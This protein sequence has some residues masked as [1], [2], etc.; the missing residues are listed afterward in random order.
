MIIF[1]FC[2]VSKTQKWGNPRLGG[3]EPKSGGTP[4]PWLKGSRRSGRAGSPKGRGIPIPC[5]KGS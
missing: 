5:L 3:L 4:M 2:Y 1:K